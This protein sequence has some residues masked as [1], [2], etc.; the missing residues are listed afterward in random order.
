MA[1]AGKKWLMGCGAGCLAV[2]ILALVLA[3]GGALLFRDT[4]A[5]WRAAD[6][7]LGELERAYGGV[8]DHVPA[9]D[10]SLRPER[11]AAFLAVH[12]RITPD[13]TEFLE[14]V[15]RARS[16]LEE[17]AAGFERFWRAV[18]TG[19]SL[20]PGLA[21][22]MRTRSEAMLEV[23]MNPGEYAYLH[24]LVFHC[25]L[26]HDPAESAVHHLRQMRLERDRHRIV[27]G[28]DINLADDPLIVARQLRQ[29][30]NQRHRAWLRSM[31]QAAP[32]ALSPGEEA[33]LQQVRSELERLQEQ[34][35]AVPWTVSFPN[36]WQEVLEPLR[37]ELTSAWSEEG[38]L[39]ELI[40]QAQADGRG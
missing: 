36:P 31:L 37:R 24:S 21:H 20:G 7:A 4:I 26:G 5:G 11:I 15:L 8:D 28:E 1:G 9:W 17:P 38:N 27:F 34:P 16:D 6:R 25:W 2:V 19:A 18:R 30:L 29:A 40:M 22:L 12:E 39:I 33:W 35:E 23:G 10:G 32:P 3:G 13:A 14:T